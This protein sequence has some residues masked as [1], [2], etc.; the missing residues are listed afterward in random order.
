M[1]KARGKPHVSCNYQSHER[2]NAI[3]GN[4]SSYEMLR[5]E[6]EKQVGKNNKYKAT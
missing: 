3:N 5:P 2:P 1:K 4:A 6:K